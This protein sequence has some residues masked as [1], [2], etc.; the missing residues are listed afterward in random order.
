MS[1]ENFFDQAQPR[2]Q[3]ET[4]AILVDSY[5]LDGA[6]A[7]NHAVVGRRLDDGRAVRV[8]LGETPSS[9]RPTIAQFAA[10]RIEKTDVSTA[11]GGVLLVQDGNLVRGDEYEARWLKSLSHHQ[12]EAE[13][14]QATA[15]VYP[16]Q[17]PKPADRNKV[18]RCVAR[19]VH[20]GD[21]SQLSQ[22]MLDTI[23]WIP[24]QRINSMLA[25]E[26]ELTER[27]CVQRVGAGIRVRRASERFDGLDLFFRQD[28]DPSDVI[29]NKLAL[30]DDALRA[31]IDSGE[32]LCEVVSFSDIWMSRDAA[33][34]VANGKDLNQARRIEQYT[35]LIDGDTA[36]RRLYRPTIFALMLGTN[37]NAG[38]HYVTWRYAEPLMNR[39]PLDGL[40]DAI[41]YM[42]TAEFSPEIPRPAEIMSAL[43]QRWS[44]QAAAAAPPAAA[45]PAGR[46]P[47]GR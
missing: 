42:Q 46:R 14:L 12:G 20:D 24:P 41:T 8:K 43:Q 19:I 27:M 9:R 15:Y 11:P 28:Q 33:Q 29:A 35:L 3:R 31:E 47:A 16:V 37:E 22:D 30:F 2:R 4:F 36:P 40:R 34:S 18:A 13:V 45:P 7:A 6:S 23:K 17:Q 39:Y 1:R 10:A 44:G 26:A 25:L 5:D 32:A 21:S 38:N